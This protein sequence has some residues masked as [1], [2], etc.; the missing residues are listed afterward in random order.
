[1]T[2]LRLLLVLLVTTLALRSAPRVPDDYRVGGW[3]I[4]PQ[5]FSFKFFTLFEAIEKSAATGGRAIELGR[6]FK[7]SPEQPVAFNHET[8]ADLIPL[9]KAK[10]KQHGVKAVNYG[11]VP[12]PNNEAA[13]RKVFDF[14]RTMELSAIITESIDALDLIEKLAIEYDIKVGIHQHAKKPNDPNYKIWDPA[15]VRDLVKN[16]DRRLGACADVGHWQTSG[17][18][19]IDGIKTLEGRIVSLHLKERAAL[20]PNQT[21]TIFGTGITDIPAILTELRRQNFDGNIAIEYEFNWHHSVPDIAQCIG[22]VRGWS[23]ANP[24]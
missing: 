18:R 4:G 17:I 8:P 23:A 24:K 14:A 7:L 6:N 20:G 5:V 10:L 11:V 15:F 2:P 21:D 22:F 1:M 16:R 12:I 13:A 9:V 3:V 19:A